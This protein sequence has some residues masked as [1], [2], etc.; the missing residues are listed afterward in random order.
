MGAY[1]TPELQ[2]PEMPNR[3]HICRCC[4]TQYYGNFCPEC[5]TKAGE[6]KPSYRTKGKI[7]LDML[8][9]GLWGALWFFIGTL[10]YFG[11]IRK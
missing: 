2:H 9:S 5:G 1:G 8:L 11:V 6:K 4:G 10:I 7:I 3:W